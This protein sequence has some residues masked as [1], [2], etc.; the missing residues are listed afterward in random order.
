MPTNALEILDGRASAPPLL[1]TGD[2]APV[3][4]AVLA[5]VAAGFPPE[6]FL[7]VTFHR[8]DGGARVRYAWTGGGEAL[9]DRIDRLA[10]A[11]GCDATDWLHIADRHQLTSARGRVTVWAYPLRPVLADVEGG[12]RGPA[13]RRDG[14]RRLLHAAAERTGQAPR[15]YAPPWLGFGPLLAA[16]RS[17]PVP[18]A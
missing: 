6:T 15:T 11:A 1:P 13:E 3:E 2:P 9:G 12:V 18:P 5:G 4:R 10:T 17:R 14:I 16:R 8:P 7:W